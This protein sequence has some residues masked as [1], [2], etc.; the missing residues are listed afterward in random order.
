MEG[1]STPCFHTSCTNSPGAKTDHNNTFYRVNFIQLFYFEIWEKKNTPWP[2]P[3]KKKIAAG[4]N[5]SVWM[6][7]ETQ[8]RTIVMSEHGGRMLQVG[9]WLVL[10]AERG[11]V[12]KGTVLSGDGW[13]DSIKSE[14]GECENLCPCVKILELCVGVWV[15]YSKSPK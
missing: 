11:S 14:L 2:L 10:S 9:R 8:V 15:L 6:S 13:K 3:K 5:S 1:K 4:S 7:R 12:S